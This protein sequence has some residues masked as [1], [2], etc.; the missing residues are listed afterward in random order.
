MIR[1]DCSGDYASRRCTGR[2]GLSQANPGLISRDLM[3]DRLAPPG[4]HADAT[5]PAACSARRPSYF[6][7]AAL[8]VGESSADRPSDFVAAAVGH[9][10]PAL[11]PLPAEHEQIAA[12]MRNMAAIL[13]GLTGGL[14]LATLDAGHG[15][16]DGHVVVTS[17]RPRRFG[18]VLPANSPGVH[19][20]WLPAI[21]LKIPAGA[22]ARPTGAV[23]AAAD[24]RSAPRRRAARARAWAF[25]PQGTTGRA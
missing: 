14:D 9:D 24:P 6:M 16:R 20:L 11:R 12:A 10:G 23:D 17:P 22:E 18:A 15:R 13:D 8:P 4:R 2:R 25:I 7:Q 1:S 21:A 5:S 3:A 19:A